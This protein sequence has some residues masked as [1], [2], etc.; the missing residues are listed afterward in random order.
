MAF[1]LRQSVRRD[2]SRIST[3]CRV[4][5]CTRCQSVVESGEPCSFVPFL[6]QV[7]PR[8]AA[9]EQALAHLPISR[10]PWGV[11]LA[12]FPRP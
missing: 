12:R 2:V 5:T 1:A 10:T 3:V 7:C 9:Q 6:I 4:H 11:G 8:C